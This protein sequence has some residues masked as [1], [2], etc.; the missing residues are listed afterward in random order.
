MKE[1][2]LA[3][4]VADLWH[5]IELAEKSCEARKAEENVRVF[6]LG[7]LG[8][9]GDTGLRGGLRCSRSMIALYLLKL[10]RN[11]EYRFGNRAGRTDGA[12]ETRTLYKPKGAATV[13]DNS[14]PGQS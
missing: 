8:G 4:R 13:E 5:T 11:Q 12:R 1:K 14:G 10:N 6:F 9:L 7:R 2:G 3:M